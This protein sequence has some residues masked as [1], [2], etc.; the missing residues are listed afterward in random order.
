MMS[1]FELVEIVFPSYFFDLQLNLRIRV[2]EQTPQ[3]EILQVDL[4][5]LFLLQP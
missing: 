1:I 2:P 5:Q 4:F 3:F